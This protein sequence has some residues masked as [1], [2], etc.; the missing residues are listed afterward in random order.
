MIGTF[1]A[2]IAYF[3]GLKNTFVNLVIQFKTR[4]S[5]I[6]IH[7]GNIRGSRLF[8]ESLIFASIIALLSKLI[9]LLV[10]Q[11][12][13]PWYF[14]IVIFITSIFF[15]YELDLYSEVFRE[16][17]YIFLKKYVSYKSWF[18]A[19][20]TFFPKFY[21]EMK[22][23]KESYKNIAFEKILIFFFYLR[24]IILAEPIVF[25]IVR[26]LVVY[27]LLFNKLLLV[28]YFISGIILIS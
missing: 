13:A 14:T 4:C 3:S 24:L 8:Q 28:V 7:F 25:A 16:P 2:F 19:N 11:I 15:N 21:L 1:S 20:L 12:Q 17:L 22:N 26:A 27:G 18:G 9:Y 6:L 23:I 10:F 5:E